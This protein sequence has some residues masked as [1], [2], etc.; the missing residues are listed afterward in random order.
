M[1]YQGLTRSWLW[2]SE[3]G[4]YLCRASVCHSADPSES[5]EN[6]VL[7]KFGKR[8]HATVFPLA[9]TSLQQYT[10]V[11]NVHR[12]W[13]ARGIVQAI[14]E[15]LP[16]V[17]KLKRKHAHAYMPILLSPE[18]QEGLKSPL[19]SMPESETA[20]VGISSK[21][22]RDSCVRTRAGVFCL[23]TALWRVGK[24]SWKPFLS[25]DLKPATRI[26]QLHS[27]KQV[28]SPRISGYSGFFK[29]KK[30]EQAHYQ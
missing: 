17:L 19:W 14:P 11:F 2:L 29:K 10:F 26:P 20:T 13:Q 21:E 27:W 4:T 24:A 9:Q 3:S 7:S 25:H 8:L 5:Q 12:T 16:S 28:C 23:P 30:N 1:T 15:R 22:S 6:W 18:S